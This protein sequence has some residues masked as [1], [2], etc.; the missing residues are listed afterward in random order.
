MMLS[1]SNVFDSLQLIALTNTLVS[2]DQ[3]HAV[4]LSA[5]SALLHHNH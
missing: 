4:D 5:I 2:V 1:F 3:V